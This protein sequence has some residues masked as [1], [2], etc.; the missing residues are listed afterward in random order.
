MQ[1]IVITGRALTPLALREGRSKNEFRTQRYIPGSALRGALAEVQR[2]LH[3]EMTAEFTS[4]FL[5]G[6]VSYGNLMPAN[7]EYDS[8]LLNQHS[9][10]AP[11][12]ATARTCKRCGGF[13]AQSQG[14]DERH[15]V[16]D[17][18]IPWLLFALSGRK[19]ASA[20]APIEACRQ[21]RCGAELTGIRGFYRRG[22]L[23]GGIGCS[24]ETTGLITRIGI[25]RM[26]GATQE[27]VLF[28][29]EV[30]PKGTVF[31][32]RCLVDEDLVDQWLPVVQEASASE[33]LRIGSARTSGLGKISISGERAEKTLTA[34]AIREGAEGFNSLLSREA[35]R[36]GIKLE[37]PYYLPLTLLSD[38]IAGD[39]L[40]RCLTSLT[41]GYW[42]REHGL[43]GARLVYQCAGHRRLSGWDGLSRLP[44]PDIYSIVM[45]S[46]FVYGFDD[47]P[48]YEQLLAVQQSGLGERLDEGFGR[49]R[50]ADQWHLEVQPL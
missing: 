22:A 13:R 11:L 18:L 4:F 1:E 32:G 49:I 44:K 26:T 23:P 17:S 8:E 21:D 29:R 25:N 43:A 39:E 3:P 5:Q 35:D 47:E 16:C 12:P 33:T 7:F 46:V 27:G 24:E 30:L 50:W 14:K 15:G 20:L 38:V 6:R 48:D 36:C 2:L 31:W 28:S 19:N 41:G 9:P 42:R 40:L 45:G 34:A 10:V 37:Q